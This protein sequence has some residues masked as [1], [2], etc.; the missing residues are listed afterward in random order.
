MKTIVNRIPT[1]NNNFLIKIE[2]ENRIYVF[3]TDKDNN[4]IKMTDKSEWDWA[5]ENWGNGFYIIQEI[6]MCEVFD[7][8]I[9]SI[10]DYTELLKTG[11]S[12]TIKPVGKNELRELFDQLDFFVHENWDLLWEGAVRLD[13]DISEDYYAPRRIQIN[14]TRLH[15]NIGLKYANGYKYSS[16]HT[17]SEENIVKTVSDLQELLDAAAKDIVTTLKIEVRTVS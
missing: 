8:I 16:D 1:K 4:L 15:K 10:P 9:K 2:K 17:P 12:L 13:Q 6:D 3:Y 11:V 7:N 5:V 14:S